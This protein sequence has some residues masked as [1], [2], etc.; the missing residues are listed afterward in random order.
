MFNSH[1]K[2]IQELSNK[3]LQKYDFCNVKDSICLYFDSFIQFIKE[4]DYFSKIDFVS[5]VTDLKKVKKQV[6][7]KLLKHLKNIADIAF[8]INN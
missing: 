7:G 4:H 3:K 1:K 6:K 8:G 5:L 2:S